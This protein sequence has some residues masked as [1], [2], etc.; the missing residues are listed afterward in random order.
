LADDAF[1]LIGALVRAAAAFFLDATGRSFFSPTPALASCDE[2]TGGGG[3][4]DD[5]GGGGEPGGGGGEPFST[6]AADGEGGAEG[7][8]S[9]ESLELAL[10]LDELLL[11]L[12]ELRGLLPLIVLLM[13][14]R[15]LRRSWSRGKA[16]YYC[17]PH[18]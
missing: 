12:P 17:G 4:G 11:L 13:G 8:W 5:G 9:S 15:S 14:R 3:G 7:A 2:P 1:F 6:D 10:L 16:G 18:Q